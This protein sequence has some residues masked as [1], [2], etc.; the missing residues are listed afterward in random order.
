MK[1][2]EVIK[3]KRLISDGGFGTMLQ[4]AGMTLG[5]TSEE[6]NLSHKD[7][8][9]DIHKQYINAGADIITANTFG[10]NA[11]KY[12]RETAK[13]M[14]FAA[15]ECA[16]KAVSE[17]GREIFVSL[18]IG[19]L[20]RL[21]KPYG[22]LD[23]EDAV[24][25]FAYTVRCGVECGV[26]FIM[27]ETMND[28]YETKAALLAAKENSSLPVFVTNVFDS[29]GKQMT[30]ADVRATVALLEGMGA[31]AIGMNCSLGPV[32]MLGLVKEFLTYSSTPII[33]QPNA[34]LP[35]ER[36]GE[37]TFDIDADEFAACMSEMAKMGAS[38]LGGCCGTTP[39][40]IRKTIEAT[41]EIPYS[42]IEKK[43]R[44]LVSSYTHAHE[45]D[46]I[47]TLIG[48]RINPTGKKKLKEA[49]REN[50]MS[51]ILSE[52]IGQGE[53]GAHILDVN[54]GLPEI[55]EVA[56]LSSAVQEIQAISD[57]PLQL[58]TVNYEAMAS[59]MRVY[60]GK[61]LVNSVNGSR[62]SMGKIFPLVKKYGGAVIALTMDESGI[63]ETASG[64]VE[65]A[66]RIIDT[67]AEYGIDKK[68]IIV[69]PLALTVS[70]N[71]ESATVTIEAIGELSRLGVKTSLGISNISFGLPER[72]NLTATF[73][74]MSLMAGL[75]CAI[76]N[77]YSYEV[78]KAYYS[79]LALS[80]MDNNFEN[81]IAFSEIAVKEQAV[82]TT[83]TKSELKL[84][85]NGGLQ[86]A[87]IKG[88]KADAKNEA[89]ALLNTCDPMEIINSHIIPALNIVGE[90][91]ENKRIYLPGLLMSADASQEAFSVIKEA[92][93]RSANDGKAPVVIA[94]VKG[95]IHDIG[96]NIV[97]VLLENFGF[98]VIDL[99]RDVPPRA[100]VDAVKESGAK[101]LCLS[102]LMTTTVKSMEE[103]ISLIKEEGI[104][105]PVMVGG[106]VLNE[107]YAKMIGADAY[108]PDAM[109]AVRYAQSVIK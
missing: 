43:N 11:L 80:G 101:L 42:F 46:H 29:T 86:N 21:L 94:T 77:P 93:P 60:N 13:N 62:E 67:A 32:Q 83:S 31:D 53:S 23:F 73:F 19:P 17:S 16:R 8:I 76:M 18:D 37:T 105:C 39:E 28:I 45:I 10:I 24:E 34:G 103:T 99:G 38:I 89:R 22:D 2:T 75:N 55:D 4:A 12:D 71:P 97:K 66:K 90:G 49:L 98:Y 107:E 44:T 88:L 52:A 91:Y 40:Y 25:T 85:G 64:R 96:K 9:V 35:V 82:K 84:E 72:D 79:Y 81:Y 65:I 14:I 87:I 26:D 7:I 54:V 59:A 41:R 51:Y 56:V 106:A 48:E 50:N 69:D 61:P 78:M 70:S 3:E 58:D 74:T 47:P 100:I 68:D 6:W 30:G 27:I 95:D 109:S 92:M 108:G 20:G 63:P 36:D 102:A 33:V 1:I 57:L 104:A 15:V 5:E